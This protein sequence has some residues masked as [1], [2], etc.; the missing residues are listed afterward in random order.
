MRK[1]KSRISFTRQLLL[2]V[3]IQYEDKDSFTANRAHIRMDFSNFR[4]CNITNHLREVSLSAFDEGLAHL[5][6]QLNPIAVFC[7][8]L[9]SRSQDPLKTSEDHVLNDIT[10]RFFGATPYIVNFKADQRFADLRFYFALRF[11]LTFLLL[12]HNDNRNGL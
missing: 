4:A 9:F 10:P 1:K 12:L 8:L 6:Q 3:P 5:P 2:Q 7:Q 11:H